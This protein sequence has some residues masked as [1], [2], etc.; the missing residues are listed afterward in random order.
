MRG[1]AF[2]EEVEA[3]ARKSVKSTK[4]TAKSFK[5][6]VKTKTDRDG[7]A[8][9]GL[10]FPSEASAG[11]YAKDLETRWSLV[12]T[13]D[14]QVCDEPPNANYPVPSDRYLVDR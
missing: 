4:Q 3:T 9:N 5:V 8:Y 10:R 12:I 14:I 13:T 2:D 1:T 6:A 11:R 7:W